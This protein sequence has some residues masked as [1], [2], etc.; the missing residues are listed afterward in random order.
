MTSPVRTDE[1]DNNST[2]FRSKRKHAPPRKSS[3][4][5]QMPQIVTMGELMNMMDT[6]D[7]KLMNHLDSKLLIYDTSI[8]RSLYDMIHTHSNNMRTDMAKLHMAA[9]KERERRRA[10]SPKLQPS[11]C[12][13]SPSGVSRKCHF[14]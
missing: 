1:C 4:F 12:G 2:S 6:R 7:Q 5:S 9:E 14:G 3:S 11:C 13:I 8:R 10:V